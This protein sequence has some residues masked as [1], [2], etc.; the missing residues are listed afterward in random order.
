MDLREKIRKEYDFERE[1]LRE[2]PVYPTVSVRV[3]G[4]Q[5]EFDVQSGSWHGDASHGYQPVCGVGHDKDTDAEIGK[6]NC[7]ILN[8]IYNISACNSICPSDIH[9]PAWPGWLGT[10]TFYK[11]ENSDEKIS[12][13]GGSVYGYIPGGMR[14]LRK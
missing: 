6:S 11:K 12:G 5:C 9:V 2:F 7:S 13:N 10:N 3:V 14:F 1:K 4:R 8:C